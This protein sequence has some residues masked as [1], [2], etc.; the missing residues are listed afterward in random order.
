[1]TQMTQTRSWRQR[2]SVVMLYMPQVY[3]QI[4]QI[5]R[6][7]IQGLSGPGPDGE[8][9]ALADNDEESGRQASSEQ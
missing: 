2:Q 8:R 9:E 1:M 3:P 6:I 5:A 7:P 4:S